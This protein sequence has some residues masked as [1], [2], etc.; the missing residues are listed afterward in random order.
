MMSL[1]PIYMHVVER[2]ETLDHFLWC[3]NSVATKLGNSKRSIKF[4]Q[5]GDNPLN[6]MTTAEA[7]RSLV[8]LLSK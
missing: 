5:C 4:Y 3:S 8:L 6:K 2:L 7:I 1:Y